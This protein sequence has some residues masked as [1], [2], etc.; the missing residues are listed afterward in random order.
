[1]SLE[2]SVFAL[3]LAYLVNGINVQRTVHGVTYV[4]TEQIVIY[5]DEFNFRTASNGMTIYSSLWEK[6]S[7]G[8]QKVIFP[9]LFSAVHCIRTKKNESTRKRHLFI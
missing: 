7:N 3:Q 6:L 8:L 5:G 1:M 4:C 2:K 9:P